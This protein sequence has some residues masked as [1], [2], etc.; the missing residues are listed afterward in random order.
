MSDLQALVAAGA[1][2]AESSRDQVRR[3]LAH[4]PVVIAGAGALGRKLARGLRAH[5]V[6]VALFVDNDPSRGGSSV[7]GIAVASAADAAQRFGSSAMFVVAIWNAG[8]RRNQVDVQRQLRGLGCRHV[9]TFGHVFRC[10]PET[11]LPYFAVDRFEGV[12]DATETIARAYDLLG[13]DA[14]RS[15]FEEQLRWRL[16]LDYE[17]LG[18]PGDE[19]QYFPPDI[20]TAGP[21]ERFA[22]CGAYDGDTLRA[23]LALT[24]SF[25]RYWAL[26]PDPVNFAALERFVASLPPQLASRVSC[27]DLAASDHRGTE[28]FDSRGSASSVLSE[29]GDTT[30]RCAPLDELVDEPTIIK[31]DVE[32]AEPKVLE[33][34]RRVI[35]QSAPVLAVSAYHTQSHLWELPLQVHALHPGYRLRYRAHN[36]EAFDL[37]LYAT[38]ND[39]RPPA[40]GATGPGA[41]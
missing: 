4:A 41:R 33:G 22:D 40:A 21:T 2:A 30:I 17:Q 3:L 38:G 26:E 19:P 31:L 14:S 8:R 29:S 25:D 5:G 10:F 13:D 27:L 7:D 36:E 24:G 37:V 23:L 32:G 34:A 28:R 1:A 9:V 16:T 20:Y 15:L 35:G 12:V 11:F 6:E 39:E 18:S